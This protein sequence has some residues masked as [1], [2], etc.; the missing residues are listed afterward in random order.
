[1]D[2]SGLYHDD[3]PPVLARLCET[4]PMLRLKDVGMNCGCEYTSFPKFRRCASYSRYDHSLGVGLI[5][6]H[7]TKDEKQAVAGLLHDISTPVFAHVVDF[8]NGDYMAQESTELA[9]EQVIRSSP[10]LLQ[11]LRDFDLSVSDVCDYHL[12]PI[13]D[14]DTPRLSSDR[15]EYTFGNALN[16]G[17][18]AADELD[19][20]YRD[21]TVGRN[22]DSIPELMFK[23]PA[24][25]LSFARAALS[26]S[27]VY[28]SDEDRF[29]MEALASRLKQA[30]SRGVL[31]HGDLMRTETEVI[32]KLCSDPV[33][34]ADWKHYQS[35]ARLVTSAVPCPGELYRVSAKK[36]HIDPMILGAGRVSRV[37]PDFKA[38]LTSYLSQPFDLWLS[39][40]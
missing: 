26:C 27:K 16:Y 11:V 3:L 1:M 28:V 5:V 25:A 30:I 36:R 31:S 22:E 17:F 23:T 13:A 6:W 21:L 40:E 34:A 10:E 8:M 4:A 39:A 35:F 33:C 12:Y 7:F 18:T 19:S 24:L 20:L 9:T 32:K 38:E 15:L 37:F 14:N 29:A 2:L